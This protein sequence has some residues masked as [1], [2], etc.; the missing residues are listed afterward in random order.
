MAIKLNKKK[1][2]IYQYGRS[3]FLIEQELS[4]LTA[5]RVPAFSFYKPTTAINKKAKKFGKTKFEKIK[6]HCHGIVSTL[7]SRL[8]MKATNECVTSNHRLTFTMEPF[9]HSPV[10]AS[11]SKFNVQCSDAELFAALSHVLCSQHGG[12]RRRL[13][14]IGLHLHSTGNPAHSFSKNKCQVVL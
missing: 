1:L 6:P 4:M 12:V 2:C 10:T 9:V 11:R 3:S 14:A 7:P 5:L 13:I 8:N